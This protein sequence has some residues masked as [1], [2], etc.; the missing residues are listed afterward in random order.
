MFVCGIHVNNCTY[1]QTHTHTHTDKLAPSDTHTQRPHSH[2]HSQATAIIIAP[3]FWRLAGLNV[4]TRLGKLLLICSCVPAS[5][6]SVFSHHKA[7]LSP[8]MAMILICYAIWHLMSIKVLLHQPQYTTRSE[9][10]LNELLKNIAEIDIPE[11][12]FL[13]FFNSVEISHIHI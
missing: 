2:S 8:F 5:I 6:H 9:H 1:L 10:R 4:T 13:I 3:H 12:V 7:P 11:S